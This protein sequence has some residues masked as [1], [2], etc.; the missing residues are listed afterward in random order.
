MEDLSKFIVVAGLHSDEALA[1]AKGLLKLEA[2]IPDPYQR[3]TIAGLAIVLAIA[4]LSQRVEFELIQALAKAE[5]EDGK[6]PNEATI[7]AQMPGGLPARIR[8][9]PIVA[10]GQRFRLDES[11]EKTQ[12]LLRAIRLRNGLIH[13]SGELLIGSADQ[14]EATVVEG[15]LS[16]RIPLPDLNWNNLVVDE[17]SDVIGAVEAILDEFELLSSSGATREFDF[18]RNVP[19]RASEQ[20]ET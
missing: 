18:F 7:R 8:L 9:L 5:A 20:P 6:R 17:A 13:E 15:S 1:R 4:H 3:S 16:L 2:L 19:K 10:Y 12:Q 14:F 11:K